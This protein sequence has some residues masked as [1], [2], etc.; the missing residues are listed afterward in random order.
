MKATTIIIITVLSLHA[1]FL[2]ASNDFPPISTNIDASSSYCVSLM[3]ITPAEATFEDDATFD[4]NELMPMTPAEAAFDD[5][6]SETTSIVNLAPMTPASA[7]FDD[8]DVVATAVDYGMLAPITPAE[9]D[10]E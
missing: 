4:M 6:P 3:P 1:S 10:F 2:F 8:D 9:A 7:D 5:M